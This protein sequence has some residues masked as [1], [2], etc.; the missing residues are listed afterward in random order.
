[1]T[2]GLQGLGSV[3]LSLRTLFTAGTV[4]GM[5]DSKLL[6]P[7]LSRSDVGTETRTRLVSYAFRPRRSISP[8]SSRLAG[9]ALLRNRIDWLPKKKC[10]V[11]QRRRRDF[12]I[13]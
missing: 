8:A 10:V 9:Q 3:L 1:M 13:T 7:F 12:Q 11:D 6:E 2:G 5:T 4:G